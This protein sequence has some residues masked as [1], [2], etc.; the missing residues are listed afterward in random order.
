MILVSGGTGN[1]GSELVR[2]LKASEKTAFRVL[3]RDRA[4]AAATLGEDVEIAQG[5]VATGEGLAAALKG[6]ERAFFVTSVGPDVGVA[7]SAFATAARAARVRRIV[8]VS[9]GTVE[10]QPPVLLGKWHVALEGALAA[11]GAACTFLRPGNFASNTLRWAP[12]IRAK[13]TVFAPLA[14]ALTVPIDPLDI[15]AVAFAA[16]HG[17]GHDGK[18][19]LLTGPEA[20]TTRQ[21]VEAI[22][23]AIGRAIEV[24]DVP[25]EKARE[26]MVGAGV[27][28]I[29]ADAIVELFGHSPPRTNTIIREITGRDAR[30]YSDWVA[31][32]VAQFG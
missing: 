10:M 32:H 7:A 12:M 11:S 14:D 8:A 31:R 15:A 27:P 22:S 13:S 3:S 4:R 29:M 21:Q 6:V 16:L 24:V 28:P 18:A 5:D 2:L 17:A 30:P 26:G 23:K 20:M 25:A 9:S 1:I 19:Y